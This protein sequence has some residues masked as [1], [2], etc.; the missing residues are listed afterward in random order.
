MSEQRRLILVAPFRV[1]ANMETSRRLSYFLAAPL[2]I[3]AACVSG[4][5]IAKEAK[6]AIIC[7]DPA[8]TYNQQFICRQE[9]EGAKTKRE[10][11]VVIKRFTERAKA[12][13]KPKK[14]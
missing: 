10:Q 3:L 6:G 8:L 1:G 4:N 5:V 11:E 13:E 12:A 7:K 14:E 2:A 9:F